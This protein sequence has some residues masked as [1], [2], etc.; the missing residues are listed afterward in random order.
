[1]ASLQEK[2]PLATREIVKLGAVGFIAGFIGG[3]VTAAVAHPRADF[4]V[5]W[6]HDSEEPVH[7]HFDD[8]FPTDAKRDRVKDSFDAWEAAP[9]DLTFVRNPAEA[10]STSGCPAE[11]KSFVIHPIMDGAGGVLAETRVCAFVGDSD[12]AKSFYIRMDRSEQWYS[13]TSTPPPDPDDI[14]VQAVITHEVGHATGFGVN[15]AQ[16]HWGQNLNGTL[17]QPQYDNLC[18]TNPKHTMCPFYEA[19]T[20]YFRS[21]E[22][23]DTHTFDNRYQARASTPPSVTDHTT[24]RR[25]NRSAVPDGSRGN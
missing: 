17:M 10:S 5:V 16:P 2:R 20:A 6:W 12:R 4:Y 23:H 3:A 22:E 15:G 9:G 11:G 19:G 25:R 1:M 14:D 8:D 7:W 18:L 24:A 21:L 13:G